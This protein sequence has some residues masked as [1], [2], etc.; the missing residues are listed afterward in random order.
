MSPK[1][2]TIPRKTMN[3]TARGRGRG[4][5]GASDVAAIASLWAM[6]W[7]FQACDIGMRPGRTSGGPNVTMM[8]GSFHHKH[9]LRGG[10]ELHCAA[11][12]LLVQP[13]MRCKNA[14]AFSG[15]YPRR[16]LER[17]ALEHRNVWERMLTYPKSFWRIAREKCRGRPFSDTLVVP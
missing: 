6:D 17:R 13:R 4:P 3:R 16:S 2:L 7:D 15:S 12:D 8:R 9:R 10:H 11:D 1:R 5:F 14:D